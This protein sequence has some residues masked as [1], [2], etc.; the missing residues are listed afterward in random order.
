MV[1]YK[2]V[3]SVGATISVLP[4]VAEESTTSELLD[5]RAEGKGEWLDVKKLAEGV[6]NKSQEPQKKR[7]RLSYTYSTSKHMWTRRGEEDNKELEKGTVYKS[8]NNLPYSP[9]IHHIPRY[10]LRCEGAE[11]TLISITKYN[12][13]SQEVEGGPFTFEVTVFSLGYICRLYANNIKFNSISF[14]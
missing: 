4:A 9:P 14:V 13:Q 8:F 3:Y 6:K 10:I 5:Q 7:V 11:I 12:W 1:P 2:G